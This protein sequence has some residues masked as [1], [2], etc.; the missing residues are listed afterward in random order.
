LTTFLR[1]HWLMII[2]LVAGAV[3]R[4][5]VQYAYWPAFWFATDSR[6]Y[7][8]AVHDI[9]PGGNG[10]AN[11]IGYP[12][13]LRALSLTDSLAVV[14][15]VQHVAMVV[16]A[17]GVYALLHRRGV[18]RWL[19]AAATLPLLFD[20]RQLVTEHYVLSDALFV[21]LLVGGMIVL[22]WQERPGVVAHVVVAAMLV[23]AAA[24]R[25]VGVAMLAL[26]AV[27]LLVRWVG[28]ARLLAF[29]LTVLV[30]F[31]GYL[32]WNHA[33]TGSFA[34]S[35][36]QGRFLYSRTAQIADC[37]KLRL[38]PAQR[39][40]CPDEPLDA[41]PERG[42]SYVW[43]D[44][45]T[46]QIPDS[47]DPLFAAFA[48]EV[49]VQQPWDY[50]ELV[51]RDLGK[52][53]LPGQEIGPKTRCLALWSTFP[54]DLGADPPV[55]Q[56]FTAASNGFDPDPAD[57]KTDRHLPLQNVFY[58]YSQYVQTPAAVLG[59]C[60]L[61][62]LVALA[63]RPRQGRYR[64]ALDAALLVSAGIGLLLISVATTLYSIRYG[65]PP[66]TLMVMGGVLALHRLAGSRGE[67]VKGWADERV[68]R[69]AEAGLPG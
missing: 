7:I 41:R 28:W 11:G 49:I 3:L 6:K 56:P 38:T 21:F 52:Y 33:E 16:L 50:A 8:N 46:K 59:A 17:A 14:A 39:T 25:T 61:I 44:K 26:V 5:G 31:G 43:L 58:V 64:D 37:S 18:N 32:A 55:C 42:D 67:P 66:L 60:V 29:G 23:A 9:R 19:A 48:R 40:L 20:E 53:L 15:I 22:L 63:W 34:M 69:R 27:Y 62:T 57:Y 13:L 24:T 12:L 36:K 65:V 30:L 10:G 2:V 54:P 1:T 45:E 35:A 47:Q 4:A 68:D 51:L